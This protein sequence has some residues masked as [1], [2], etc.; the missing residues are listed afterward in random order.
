MKLKLFIVT[1]FLVMLS[2]KDDSVVYKTTS[3]AYASKTG[4]FYAKFPTKPNLSIQDNKIGADEFEVFAYRSTLGPNKIFSIEYF[5]Y[6]GEMVKAMPNEQFL[7]QAVTNYSYAMAS[8]FELDFKEPVNNGDLKGVYFVLQLKE[9][10]AIKGIEGMILGEIFKIGN[11]VY[12]ITYHGI[13]DKRVD[14]FIESFK[15]MK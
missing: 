5:D 2:C 13:P 7:D 10:P 3:G 12:T 6:P 11:R 8:N 4:K 1:L 9:N 15:I 14:T